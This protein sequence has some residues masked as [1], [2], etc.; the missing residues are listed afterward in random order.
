M[1][2]PNT[3]M[4]LHRRRWVA[5]AA[6]AILLLGIG[7]FGW[8]VLRSPATNQ[9]IVKTKEQQPDIM[10]GR[11]G[12]WLTLADGSKKLLDSLG[13]GIIAEQEGTS[14]KLENG[15]IAY[16]ATK[17]DAVQYNTMTTPRGRIFRLV[18]PDGTKRLAQ[19]SKFNNL[20][21]SIYSK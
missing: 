14:I 3:V 8:Y 15:Q 17:A 4:P 2:I 19:C 5:Y 13:N 10:P 12:A 18:L 20:S 16:D 21:N 11:Q 6:A 9:S 7:F 1:K